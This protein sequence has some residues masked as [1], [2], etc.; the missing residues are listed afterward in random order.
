MDRNDSNRSR[1]TAG[2]ISEFAPALFVLMFIFLFPL[3]NMLWLAASYMIILLAA[4]VTVSAAAV[5]TS[6][7]R[8][9]ASMYSQANQFNGSAW[10]AFGGLIPHGGYGN[11]G[12]DLY[13]KST[14]I[15]SHNV[16]RFGPNTSAPPPIDLSTK[17][18]EFESKVSYQVHP[19]INMA[20]VPLVGDVPALGK[21]VLIQCCAHKLAE[22]PE[23]LGQEDEAV[24]FGSQPAGSLINASLPSGTGG[25]GVLPGES[26]WNEPTIYE[27]IKAAGQTIVAENVVTVRAD[28]NLWTPIDVPD[29][30]PGQKIWIDY[31][32]DGSWNTVPT[33]GPDN[34]QDIF[35][36]ADGLSSITTHGY[37]LGAMLG[38][39]GTNT[40]FLL[41]KQQWNL[42]PPGTGKFYMICND[43]PSGDEPMPF[44]GE[45]NGGH[46][47][48]QG[49][50]VV[51]VIIAK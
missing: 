31:R 29:I 20:A 16:N 17:V 2:N 33:F 49:V 32:A 28:N 45:T 36:D 40:P 11:S 15:A 21:D 43:G 7:D 26:S 8:A 10:N 35:T 12:S 37:P 22:H 14:D 48:N 44:D 50:M 23:G 46:Y 25:G 6:Y 27:K 39:V 38:R 3:I 41:G 34:Y 24:E 30:Q 1:N 51:R 42:T 13:L 18:W 19:L 4:N 5:E 9:L 47:N